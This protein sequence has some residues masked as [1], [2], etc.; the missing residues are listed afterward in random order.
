[1]IYSAFHKLK[2]PTIAVLTFIYPAVAV[3]S[4]IVFYGRRLDLNQVLGMALI[5]L[6]NLGS[7]QGWTLGVAW[8]RRPKLSS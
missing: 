6:A 1:L 8:L 4:D 2:T 3:L 7:A 5:L